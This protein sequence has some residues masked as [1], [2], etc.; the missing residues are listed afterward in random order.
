M[1][2]GERVQKLK[3][4]QSPFRYDRAM[5]AAFF[6]FFAELNDL[7]PREWRGREV[8]HEFN[9][10]ASVKD[11]IE[12]H[13]VPHTEVQLIQVN[14][15]PVGFE[16]LLRDGDRV[17]VYPLMAILESP[18]SLRPPYPRGRFVLDQHLGRLAAYLRLLGLDCV[19]HSTFPDDEIVRVALAEARVVLT[20][21]KRLLMRR[22]VAHGGF[23]HAT[24]PFEQVP[25]VLHRFGAPELVAPF[26]RCMACNGVLRAVGREEVEDRL[27]PDTREYYREFRE[28]PDC[29]RVYWD[30][31]H[32]RRM[33]A[34]V[35]AWLTMIGR[36]SPE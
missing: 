33:R 11:R 10:P 8:V 15:E 36:P 3:W 21:D 4:G 20:R 25:E 26:S 14:G 12:A 35:H 30:G 23:V 27:L 24:D 9:E 16:R 29:R 19:H 6:R 1:R 31:S 7:L 17:S 22:V 32:A 5:A 28:C 13:G 2:R 34:W 18:H